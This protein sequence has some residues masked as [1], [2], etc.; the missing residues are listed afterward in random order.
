MIYTDVRGTD[1]AHATTDDGFCTFTD[2]SLDC[3]F[4]VLN[5][6]SVFPK[7]S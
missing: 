2:N 1:N 5:P 3:Q 4:H 7:Y 6:T